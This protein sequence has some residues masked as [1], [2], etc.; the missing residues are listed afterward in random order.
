MGVTEHNTALTFYRLINADVKN[1]FTRSC[2]FTRPAALALIYS[3]DTGNL[4][5]V[6]QHPLSS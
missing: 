2:L 6:V 1:L 5:N 4:T 3:H